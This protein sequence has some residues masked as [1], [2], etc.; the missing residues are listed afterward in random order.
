VNSQIGCLRMVRSE[1]LLI[2]SVWSVCVL[3]MSLPCV[4]SEAAETL[5]GRV[6]CFLIGYITPNICPFTDYFA[7]DPLFVYSLEPINEAW[8]LDERR[9]SDRSYYPRTRKSLAESFDMMVLWGAHIE[10]F[11]TNQVQ[12]LDHVFRREKMSCFAH[13][14]SEWTNVWEPS[15]LYSTA[16]VSEY[17]T[18]VVRPY[19]LVFLTE[20]EQVFTP[21]IELGV[22]KIPG[23]GYHHMKARQGAAT[24]ANIEPEDLPFLVSWRPGGGD[25]GM[26]WVC[27]D[28]EWWP[29][30]TQSSPHIIDL[31][32]NLIL[33]SLGRALIS[34]IHARGQARD[35]LSGFQAQKRVV[36][37]TMD[38]A[39]SF[40]ANILPLFEEL[41][42]LESVAEEA[43][44]YYLGQDYPTT[45]TVVETLRS[46]T[47]E[48]TSEATRL[49]EQAMLWVFITEWM[50]VTSTSTI[51]GTILWS[52]MVRRR[53]YRTLKTT[54][55][56]S[57]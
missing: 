57:A 14:G 38:W 46:R 8:T 11:T 23:R 1:S 22:Q 5:D 27:P 32:T 40:G 29:I 36:L 50:A 51:A 21:F 30:A 53:K 17:H 39:D 6:S 13:F 34:D 20:R 54:R 44:A 26:L 56:N 4:S 35:L 7:Q 48:I 41:A 15:V 25:A 55:L 52:L 43:T 28:W 37:S 31:A 45:I 10:H 12:D 49:K 24:W 2:W 19:R 47:N 16:P 18:Y 33:H 9:R 3:T 42:D